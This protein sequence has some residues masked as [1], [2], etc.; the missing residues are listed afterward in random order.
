[1]TERAA[2]QRDYHIEL[3]NEHTNSIL[4]RGFSDT[5]KDIA[6]EIAANELSK[7]EPIRKVSEAHSQPTYSAGEK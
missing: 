1:M 7:I 6:V 3:I 5:T 4:Y 2:Y